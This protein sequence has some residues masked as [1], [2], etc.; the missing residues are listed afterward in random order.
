[1][2]VTM[3]A[4]LTMCLQIGEL[5]GQGISSLPLLQVSLSLSL[6]LCV[7]LS[8]SLSLYLSLSLRGW[9]TEY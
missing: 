1:M 9:I 4:P 6:Y 5:Y 3:A 8:L 2:L 7:S